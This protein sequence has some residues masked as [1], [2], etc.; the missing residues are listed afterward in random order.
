MKHTKTTASNSSI[1][2]YCVC[3]TDCDFK[4]SCGN[5]SLCSCT[6]PSVHLFHQERSTELHRVLFLLIL[7]LVNF[8][9]YCVHLWFIQDRLRVLNFYIWHERSPLTDP[10]WTPQEV[11][12]SDQQTGEKQS[13]EDASWT[14]AHHVVFHFHVVGENREDKVQKKLWILL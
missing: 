5:K 8:H 13:Y 12:A 11:C 2:V 14:E 3:L 10:I 7:L 9:P 1:S 4:H 6:T